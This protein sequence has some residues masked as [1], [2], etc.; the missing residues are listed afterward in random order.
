MHNLNLLIILRAI[1]YF[2]MK[3]SYLLSLFFIK[4]NNL[5]LNW[6]QDYYKFKLVIK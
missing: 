5:Q 4:S 3:M 6:I 1:S 2:D